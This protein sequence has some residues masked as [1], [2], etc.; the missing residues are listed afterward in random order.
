MVFLQLLYI[1]D[2]I[3]IV[4]IFCGKFA[5]QSTQIDMII[6]PDKLA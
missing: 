5:T 2:R 3:T 1:G 4:I 6:I